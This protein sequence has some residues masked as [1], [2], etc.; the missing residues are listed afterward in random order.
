M[1]SCRPLPGFSEAG[2]PPRG[3]TDFAMIRPGCYDPVERLKDMDI[4]GV[5]GQL[6]LT[7]YARCAGHR[8]FLDIKDADLALACLRTYNDYLI[9]EWCA[10]D[11]ER[12]YG[13]A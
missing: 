13:A 7:N 6:C 3:T 11:P 10:T 8:V 2:Y 4:D 1:G 9:D 5:W 12:L